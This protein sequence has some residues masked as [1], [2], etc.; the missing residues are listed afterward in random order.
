MN[1]ALTEIAIQ[2]KGNLAFLLGL[3]GMF[4]IVKG[5]LTGVLVLPDVEKQRPSIKADAGKIRRSLIVSAITSAILFAGAAW[6]YLGPLAS[7][8]AEQLKKGVALTTGQ[9]WA[10]GG[11][12]FISVLMVCGESYSSVQRYKFSVLAGKT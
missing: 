12:V 1:D 7:V 11:L 6:L 10:V 2:L 3:G 9:V 8:D 5:L 4:T